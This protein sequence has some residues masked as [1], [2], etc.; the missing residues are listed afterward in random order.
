MMIMA[1]MVMIVAK[2]LEVID[3]RETDVIPMIDIE[4][5][6]ITIE[7]IVEIDLLVD[8][9]IDPIHRKNFDNIYFVLN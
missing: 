3:T 6:I 8:I 1:E 5:G 9:D 2:S 7:K 4:T